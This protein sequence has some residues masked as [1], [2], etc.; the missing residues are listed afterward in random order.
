MVSAV[1]KTGSTASTIIAQPDALAPKL[2]EALLN[3]EVASSYSAA[4]LPSLPATWPFTS[5]RPVPAVS[6]VVVLSPSSP[7][8]ISS[9]FVV[10]TPVTVGVL[11]V[12]LL[13]EYG[14]PEFGSNG[15]LVFAP[16]T[17]NTTTAAASEEDRVPLNV[18]VIEVTVELEPTTA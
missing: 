8:I 1:K 15:L 7:I 10:V 12:L 17:P 6:A 14:K 13:A 16:D 2:T 5:V 18:T 4:A 11:A 9:G 3:G